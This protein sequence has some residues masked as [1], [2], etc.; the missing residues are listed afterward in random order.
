MSTG[1]GEIKEDP[2]PSEYSPPENRQKRVVLLMVGNLA[3]ALISFFNV[4]FTPLK[5]FW[6]INLVLYLFLYWKYRRI[7]I[8]P[9]IIIGTI[10]LYLLI[11]SITL[12]GIPVAWIAFIAP[13]I[14]SSFAVLAMVS[15]ANRRPFTL[16]YTLG[17]EDT[18]ALHWTT[19]ILWTVLYITAAISSFIFIPHLSFILIPFGLMVIGIFSTLFFHF[20]SLWPISR[21]LETFEY[22]GHT[23][24]RISPDDKKKAE[25]FYNLLIQQYL[26]EHRRYSKSGKALSLEEIKKKYKE[27]DEKRIPYIHRFIAYDRDKP[28][29]TVCV[30]MD[31]PVWG[32]QS[33]EKSG[34]SCNSIKACGRIGEIGKFSTARNYRYNQALIKGL[35][36]C[37]LDYL[38]SQGVVIVASY[39]FDY[40]TAMWQRFGFMPLLETAIPHPENNMYIEGSQMM[41]MI[42]NLSRMIFYSGSDAGGTK[43]RH[44]L[45]SYYASRTFKRLV[46]KDFF[47]RGRSGVQDIS[48]NRLVKML[49]KGQQAP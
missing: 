39:S 15:I 25:D 43:D 18:L 27:G 20:Y 6:L 2:G 26:N 37:A 48:E 14:Y 44:L 49:R 35:F 42:M 31:H 13:C 4:Y 34:V 3:I 28:I 45:N 19:S 32:L 46:L 40:T 24:S 21:L 5:T 41:P 29:G 11:G 47:S 22:N 8:R 30:Y 7:G 12:A 38:L 17:K 33:E 16:A 23:F 10:I 9:N 36:K 1:K